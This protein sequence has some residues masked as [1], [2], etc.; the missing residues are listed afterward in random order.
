MA[1][2]QQILTPTTS[3][4]SRYH[5]YS[6]GRNFEFYPEQGISLTLVDT[7][8]EMLKKAVGKK[9]NRN[10]KFYEMSAES[11]QFPDDSF[12]VVVDTYGLCS[13]DNPVKALQEM[14]R[15]CKPGMVQSCAPYPVPK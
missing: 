10:A 14:Q 15:V 12:D 7:S 1:C 11:L 4:L 8:K 5:P 13:I 2:L 6:T 9:G 3:S